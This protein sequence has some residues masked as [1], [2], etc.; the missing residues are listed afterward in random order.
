MNKLS[1]LNP[2]RWLWGAT[3]FIYMW[4]VSIPLPLLLI[5]SPAIVSLSAV[6]LGVL[7]TYQSNSQWRRSLVVAQL[8]NARQ[9]EN[10]DE[11][12]LL[13][14]RL[15]LD[16]PQDLEL[17]FAAALATLAKGDAPA[18]QESIER[19]AT[20]QA[21]GPAAIWT[22]EKKFASIE[23]PKWDEEKR[24][25]FGRLIEVALSASPNDIR[26]VSHYAD[27]LLSTGA[28]EKALGEIQKLV[29]VQPGRALQGALILR[30]S[31]R[32]SQAINLAKEGL[33][34][35]EK[36]GSESPDNV[37]LALLRAQ[38]HLFLA[39]Y[40]AAGALLNKASKTSEDSRLRTGLAEVL[41]LWSRDQA[42]IASPTERFARQLQL[43]NNA[44]KLAPNHPLVVSDLMNVILQCADEKDPKVA[45]LRDILVQGIAPELAHFVRGTSAMIQGDVEMAT[46]HLELAA[47]SLPSAPAVLNNL[48]VTIATQE[49][50]DLD[51]AMQLVDAALKQV[52]DQPY[53]HETKAQIQLRQKDYAGAIVSFEKSLPAE[54]L[55]AQVHEGLEKA[56]AA[57]G[58]TELAE[59]H[60]QQRERLKQLEEGKEKN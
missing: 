5:S 55:R 46:L 48:A 42:S 6:L 56:Y 43:L 49:S 24:A 53:F 22:L 15:L 25:K 34:L 26:L 27:Y 14:K 51:R 57:L 45:Q 31:G 20:N 37:E 47:K 17:R 36:Q 30:K 4:I 60:Q 39:Q 3:E 18:A 16:T 1:R 28:T 40:E 50:P 29:P 7:L 59:M 33:R 23:W 32:E 38:Y 9:Q 58:Q 21:Y 44:L 12:L 41:V 54:A 52:P 13:T 11:V 2:V 35:L 8:A 19:L 10:H